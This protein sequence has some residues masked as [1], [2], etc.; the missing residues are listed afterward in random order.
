MGANRFRVGNLAFL[1][2]LNYRGKT[3]RLKWQTTGISRFQ[4]GRTERINSS[5]PDKQQP[6][7]VVA[8]SVDKSEAIRIEIRFEPQ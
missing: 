6:V 5:A 8:H 1:N 7:V 2:A 3:R 4:A